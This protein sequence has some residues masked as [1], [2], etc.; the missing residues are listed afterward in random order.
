MR[1][2]RSIQRSH[3]S[4]R[5]FTLTELMVAVVVL[6]VII[7]AVGRIFGTASEVVKKGEASANI[8]QET[9]A[10]EQLLRSDLDR[11]S[12][13]GFLLVQCV[14]VDNDV[15]A[16]NG[17]G[18]LLDPTLPP[19]HVFRCDQIVFVT[20]DLAISRQ[21]Q[22]MGQF[23]EKQPDAQGYVD[24]L[25]Q[26]RPTPQS[27]ASVLYYGHGIQF[28][29]L[30]QNLAWP[31]DLYSGQGE[32]TVQP[33]FRPNPGQGRLDF[34]RWPGGQN[35]GLFNATQPPAPQ[36][37]LARQDTLL[38]DDYD[39]DRTHYL[40]KRTPTGLYRNAAA[41][42]FD[43]VMES[44]RVDVLSSDIGRLRN[45][46]RGLSGQAIADFLADYRPRAEK[47][48][49]TLDKSDVLLVGNVLASNC[50]SFVVDWTWADGV[51]RDL[52][53]DLAASPLGSLAG[54][55]R[56]VS[57]RGG[58]RSTVGNEVGFTVTEAS[59]GS[60]W[61]GLGG[62]GTGNPNADVARAREWVGNDPPD[63]TSRFVDRTVRFHAPLV[64][65]PGNQIYQG[66]SPPAGGVS[67]P[68]ATLD[69]NVPAEIEGFVDT[70]IPGVRRYR[71]YFGLNG[72]E[73][74]VRDGSGSV[75]TTASFG[76]Q[77]GWPFFRQDYTPWPSALRITATFHDPRGAIEGG[78]TL[79]F[80]IPLPERVQ[81]LPES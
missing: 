4:A 24:Y 25:D 20:D 28:P 78:R 75:I 61:F 74:F 58:S 36:W 21:T 44:G 45:D 69:P 73:P 59:G 38:A 7:L 15:M 79:Q 8:L 50:S 1:D 52:E 68:G 10:I 43:P 53:L 40:S 6:L 14:A 54:A 9:A 48:P 35:A 22:T 64:Y 62:G 26:T 80:V 81:D 57:H 27:T 13:Q 16:Q 67:L 63:G 11:I 71:A 60:P 47:R 37:T 76:D 41:E 49:P 77:G 18:Q 3:Q 70:S 19:D 30:P 72:K 42:F 17:G 51:G 55:M 39:G 32:V 29:F 33:W 34:Q 2:D 46:I 5:G 23:V 65:D 12:D 66:A 31:V 56:G